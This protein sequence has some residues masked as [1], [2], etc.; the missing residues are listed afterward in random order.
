MP[1]LFLHYT[2]FFVKVVADTRRLDAIKLF[3]LLCM[4][5]DHVNTIFFNRELA[6][7]YV[8]G[9]LAFPI[10]AVVF[11][12]NLAMRPDR[13]QDST[14]RTFLA[15]VL[16]QPFYLLAFF[17]Q[18]WVPWYGLNILFAFGAAGLVLHFWRTPTFFRRSSALLVLAGFSFLL[19][20]DSYGLAGLVLILS[21]YYCAV[22]TGTRKAFVGS[23]AWW[24]A[25]LVINRYHLVL[26]IGIPVLVWGAVNLCVFVDYVKFLRCRFMPR[27]AF[28]WL[29]GGHLALLWGIAFV[30]VRV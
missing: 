7:L 13:L 20:P 16:C 3:A 11:G 25:L 22:H 12:F 30:A 29:Y 19:A 2:P 28:Y 27:R 15:G 10:F 24:T 8:F 1:P 26:M 14:R 21:S 6:V 9:R 17:G 5:G 4:V 18:P 23:L